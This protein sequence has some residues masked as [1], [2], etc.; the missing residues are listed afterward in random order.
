MWA[1]AV[2]IMIGQDIGV[3]VEKSHINVPFRTQE[4]IFP[5]CL[6]VAGGGDV[7]GISCFL[8]GSNVL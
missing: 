3:K 8:V 7:W 4:P 2:S 5:A 6:R 1:D